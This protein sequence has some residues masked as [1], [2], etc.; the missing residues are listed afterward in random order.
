MG[1]LDVNDSLIRTL[2]NEASVHVERATG[3]DLD[4]TTLKSRV[5]PKE[6]GYEEVLLG[7]LRSLGRD[8]D[9]NAPRSLVDRLVEYIIEANVLAA[10]QPGTGELLVVRENVDESNLDGLRLVLSHELVHRGQHLHHGQVFSRVD[11]NLR[12][13]MKA[14]ES[15]PPNIEGSLGY[16]EKTQ[17]AMTLIESHAAYI[18][19]RLK[20]EVYP[21][22]QI[23][24][25]FNLAAVLMRVLVGPKVTQYTQ[26]LPMVADAVSSGGLE[27]LF[28]RFE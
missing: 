28:R 10:Y 9:E 22:A 14:L 8:V 1:K 6:R 7:R 13:A 23:E 24:S 5:L 2:I 21:Q 18:T 17:E 11:E 16:M 26:G 27:N 25:H 12:L 3:W 20:Q 4:I 15:S 19:A